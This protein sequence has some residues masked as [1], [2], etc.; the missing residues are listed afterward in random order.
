[1]YIV[2][3]VDLEDIVMC[4]ATGGEGGEGVNFWLSV[5]TALQAL[6]VEDIFIACIKYAGMFVRNALEFFQDE[7]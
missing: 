1:M 6:G 2:L 7:E 4:S 5:I 3:G